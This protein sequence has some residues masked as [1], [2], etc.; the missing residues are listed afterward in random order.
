M[1]YKLKRRK[2]MADN[3]KRVAWGRRIRDELV[4]YSSR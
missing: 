2:V 3:M 1:H 4:D